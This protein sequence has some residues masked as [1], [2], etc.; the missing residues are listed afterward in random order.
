[1]TRTPLHTPRLSLVV[2][3]HG[4]DLFASNP[5]RSAGLTCTGEGSRDAGHWQRAATREKSLQG[6]SPPTH[7][8]G[9]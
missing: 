6:P 3:H 2:F 4:L 1:M 8:W 5:P 7:I 9:T